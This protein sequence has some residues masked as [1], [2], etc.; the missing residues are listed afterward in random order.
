MELEDAGRSERKLERD[1]ENLPH[2]A[3]DYEASGLVW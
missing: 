2:Q 1:E 3:T